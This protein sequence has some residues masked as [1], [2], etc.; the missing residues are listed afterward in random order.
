MTEL[1]IPWVLGII[2]ALFGGFISYLFS[3]AKYKLEIEELKAKLNM[4]EL[5]REKEQ[6]EVEKLRVEI[7]ILKQQ[8]MRLLS[9][10]F[11]NKLIDKVGELAPDQRRIHGSILKEAFLALRE[12]GEAQSNTL[13]SSIVAI[14]IRYKG[15]KLPNKELI[16]A[17]AEIEEYK[18]EI[19]AQEH[20]VFNRY[21]ALDDLPYDER[22]KA[23]APVEQ[24]R[25]Q[26]HMQMRRLMALRGEILQS[27]LEPGVSLPNANLEDANI[28]GIDLSQ[29]RLFHAN[30]RRAELQLVNLEYANLEDADLTWAKMGGANL[31][32]ACLRRACLNDADLRDADLR[33]ADLSGA[34]IRE[35]NFTNANIDDAIFNGAKYDKDT[36][37]PDGF[38]PEVAGAQIE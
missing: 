21:Q 17:L 23:R 36:T 25:K 16:R 20:L 38:N 5:E 10:D 12:S 24:E 26:L 13:E 30:L 3:R 15:R 8:E 22:K 27:S 1:L 33:G 37:W 35:T 11:W 32:K 34:D 18:E 9:D 2:T 28:A 7:S 4:R 29:A 14:S 19:I 6:L 31:H